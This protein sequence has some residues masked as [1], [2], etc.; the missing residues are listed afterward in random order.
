[1]NVASAGLGADLANKIARLVEERGWNQEDFARISQLNRHTV[2]QIL[3]KLGG[4]RG[5]RTF[6][7]TPEQVADD[8]ELW[9][10]T[11][12]ADGFNVMPAV[13]PSGLEEFVDGVVPLLQR[14][15]LFREEYAGDTLRDHYGLPVPPSLAARSAAS[16]RALVGA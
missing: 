14:R 10:T 8:L 5:H 7:G 11:D 9:F 1:M 4:G 12:A 16:D 6:V 2:R 13:L 15:G 3:Q